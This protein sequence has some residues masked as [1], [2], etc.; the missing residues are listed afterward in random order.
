MSPGESRFEE[1]YFCAVGALTPRK[2]LIT[3]LKAWDLWL[4]KHPERRGFR[5]KIAGNAHFKDTH[6]EKALSELKYLDTVKWLGRLEDN[7]LEQLYRG[8][9]RLL[10]AERHGGIWHTRSGSHAMWYAGDGLK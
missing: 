3:L 6:F 1:N 7:D 4:D 5:L 8:A 9:S 2:N 10:Y